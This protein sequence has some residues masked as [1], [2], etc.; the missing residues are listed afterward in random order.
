MSWKH[1]DRLGKGQGLGYE[2]WFF[3]K[4]NSLHG[5]GPQLI[6]SV[7]TFLLFSPNPRVSSLFPN[8]LLFF[9]SFVFVCFSIASKRMCWGCQG[10]KFHWDEEQNWELQEF[11]C[12]RYETAFHAPQI[13][14][15]MV[16]TVHVHE[17]SLLI[18]CCLLSWFVVL[19]FQMFWLSLAS[20]FIAWINGVLPLAVWI[21]SEMLE[22]SWEADLSS[23]NPFVW[24]RLKQ[25]LCSEHAS[26]TAFT[27]RP[28]WAAF[29]TER[30]TGRFVEGQIYIYFFFK[31]KPSVKHMKHVKLNLVMH[32]I[33]FI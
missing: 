3:Y 28:V 24:P 11:F 4:L 18:R 12:R 26:S 1:P 29:W 17:S 32:Y 27:G 13:T 22:L 14:T 5:K 33:L 23:D 9:C 10:F 25:L 31:D 20:F 21:T 8:F 6:Q 19:L 16:K 30:K 2:F 7:L 15:R